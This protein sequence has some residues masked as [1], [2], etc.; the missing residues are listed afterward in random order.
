MLAVALS[1]VVGFLASRRAYDCG[2]RLESILLTALT[3]LLV[4]PISWTGHWVWALPI[5]TLLWFR[6]IEAAR[7]AR[8]LERWRRRA[9][10]LAALAVVWTVTV[11]A[12]LPWHAPY[13]GDREYTHRGFDLFLG[14]SYAICGA[15]AL[16][17]GAYEF[18]RRVRR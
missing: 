9:G 7:A 18:R 4:S 12:G 17:L 10:V 11:A 8:S 5:C 14:N 6:T 2:Y 15:A 1:C 13:L 3:G 16:L